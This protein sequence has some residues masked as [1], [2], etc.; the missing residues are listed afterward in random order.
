MWSR[1]TH[2]RVDRGTVIA[3]GDLSQFDNLARPANEIGRMDAI[4]RNAAPLLFTERP[5]TQAYLRKRR[6]KSEI[7]DPTSSGVVSWM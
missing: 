4:I 3:I 7:A 1:D 5:E 6:T 2:E